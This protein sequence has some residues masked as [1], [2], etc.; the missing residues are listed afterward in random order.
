MEG[1]DRRFGEQCA[2]GPSPVNGRSSPQSVDSAESGIGSSYTPQMFESVSNGREEVCASLSQLESVELARIF[3]HA[4]DSKESGTETEA[5]QEAL[6]ANSSEIFPDGENGSHSRPHAILTHDL[7]AIAVELH[8]RDKELE[9]AARVGQELLERNSLLTSDLR[10]AAA[11]RDDLEREM[12]HLRRQLSVKEH[13]MQ[14][15]AQEVEEAD[16]ERVASPCSASVV[17]GS[18]STLSEEAAALLAEECLELREA[19][20]L[21]A[22]QV[23][24]MRDQANSLDRRE[25]E[26][27]ADCVARLNGAS[28]QIA[29]LQRGTLERDELSQQH[30]HEIAGLRVSNARSELAHR[31]L[32][33]EKASLEQ[34]L[35]ETNARHSELASMVSDVMILTLEIATVLL[36]Y[37]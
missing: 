21:L 26:L 32:E 15:Y 28:E 1:R 16:R 36:I 13:M 9:L 18:S 23:S 3:L 30:A 20:R 22:E 5:E 27:I 29:D 19:N 12:A 4:Q 34:A 6:A 2:L 33:L 25:H 31:Q 24:L 35:V 11:S 14:L 37:Y 17:S 10:E 8:R 7:D